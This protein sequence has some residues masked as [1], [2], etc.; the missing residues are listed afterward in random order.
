MDS[1]EEPVKQQEQSGRVSYSASFKVVARERSAV[2]WATRE[3]TERV[4]SSASSSGSVDGG[5]FFRDQS[6]RRGRKRHLRFDSSWRVE[7]EG[8]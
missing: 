2:V 1:R 3:A 7:R 5:G 4:C 8:V 6:W